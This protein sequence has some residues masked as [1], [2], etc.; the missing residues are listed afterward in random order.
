MEPKAYCQRTGRICYLGDLR[1]E[2]NGLRVHKSVYTP[3]HPQLELQAVPDDLTVTNPSPELAWRFVDG[4]GGSI[5]D[6]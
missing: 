6:L 3:K 5:E 2:W 4:G 1:T